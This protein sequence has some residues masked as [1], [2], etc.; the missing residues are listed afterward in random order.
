MKNEKNF[1]QNVENE[2]KDSLKIQLEPF[3]EFL[4]NDLINS[5]S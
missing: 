3:K 4:D 2:R 5:L 1:L